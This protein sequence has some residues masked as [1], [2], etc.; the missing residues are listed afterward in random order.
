LLSGEHFDTP[1]LGQAG[2]E[3]V[4]HL[5]ASW[6]ASIGR[7]NDMGTIAPLA[8]SAVELSS[9]RIFFRAKDR[10]AK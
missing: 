8:R 7:D 6:F 10:A 5:P 3:L 9:M 2:P 4:C 1:F